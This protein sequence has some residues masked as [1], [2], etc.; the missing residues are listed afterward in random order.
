M[1]DHDLLAIELDDQYP[2]T[3]ALDLASARPIEV[4]GDD[5]VSVSDGKNQAHWPALVRTELV[6]HTNLKQ[7]V[8]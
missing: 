5:V 2:I 3:R 1:H 8:A 4:P 6:D 7:V